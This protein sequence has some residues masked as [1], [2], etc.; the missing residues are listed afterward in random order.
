MHYLLFYDVVENY[1]EKRVPYRPEHFALARQFAARGELLLGGAFAD[2]IDGAV[3]L[4]KGEGPEDLIFLPDIQVSDKVTGAS[5][6]VEVDNG[7]VQNFLCRVLELLYPF[8]IEDPAK[9]DDTVIL[10]L[11]D[12]PF[13][14][15][16]V[17]GYII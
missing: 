5:F 12:L 17:F 14:N 10:I 2:P 16:L 13:R 11:F 3:L 6:G 4:F 8:E 1:A 9:A 7:L 15:Q